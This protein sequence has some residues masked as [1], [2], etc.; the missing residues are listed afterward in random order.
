MMTMP[1]LRELIPTE[2]KEMIDRYILNY[3]VNKDRYINEERRAT[4]D[5]ILKP[6]ADSKSLY[7]R[8]L[9]QD[10]LIVKQDISFSAPKD[11][12]VDKMTNSYEI[13]EFRREFHKWIDNYIHQLY[14][15]TNDGNEEDSYYTGVGLRHLIEF[16]TLAHN[17]YSYDTITIITPKG[18]KIILAEGCKPVK[19]IGKLN[20]AF[21]ISEKFEA[22]RIAVS[23]ILNVKNVKGKLCLSIHPMD[24]MTMSD[25]NCNWESC[26]SWI[27][28]GSYRQGTVEMM[29]SPYVI[30]AYIRAKDDMRTF[31]DYWNNKRWRSLYIVHP[32]F[33]GNIKG[34]PY[35]A[36]EIDK[37]IFEKLK[38]MSAAAGFQAQYSEIQQYD[39]NNY[40]VAI[41]GKEMG[42]NF[43]TE[44]MYNDFGTTDHYCCVREDLD[45]DCFDLDYSGPSECMWCGNTNIDI[46]CEEYLVCSDCDET[47]HCS[48][49]GNSFNEDELYYTNNGHVC[50]MCLQQYFEEDAR[51]GEYWYRE[52]LMQ[53]YV[54]PDSFKEGVENK[55]I[56]IKFNAYCAEN[57]PTFFDC[58]YFIYGVVTEQQKNKIKEFEEVTLVEDAHLNYCENEYGVGYFYTYQ[59]DLLPRFKSYISNQCYNRGYD[60][61]ELWY[62]SDRVSYASDEA[63]KK[64]RDPLLEDY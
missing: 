60:F 6:W 58:D 2:E 43:H 47:F 51:H 38:E 12:V 4:V 3:A 28:W 45:T 5:K 48:C 53:I 42:V 30:V 22:F 52:D 8:T 19:M 39:Y 50:E 15:K 40:R 62:H 57:L 55:D 16:E 37:I 33:F 46:E 14:V 61:E 24:Y 56:L 21:H 41:N 25:N 63:R 26:M 17:S 59:S 36:P 34:Y 54:L 20:A 49:C 13:C 23:M 10:K 27:N 9:F 31:N 18:H 1:D 7:L 64:Y 44:Y 29:N 11:D 32:D 35:Q